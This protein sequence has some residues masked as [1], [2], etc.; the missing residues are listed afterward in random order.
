MSSRL[1][2]CMLPVVEQVNPFLGHDLLPIGGGWPPQVAK[3]PNPFRLTVADPNFLFLFI[4]FI[5]FGGI[6]EIS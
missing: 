4:Y 3:W 1:M 6:F 5:E 2:L